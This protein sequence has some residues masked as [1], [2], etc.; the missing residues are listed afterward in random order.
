VLA[1]AFAELAELAELAVVPAVVLVVLFP[2]AVELAVLGALHHA[3]WPVLAGDFDSLVVPAAEGCQ[4]SAVAGLVHSVA[5]VDGAVWLRLQPW[6][7]LW[8][9]LCDSFRVGDHGGDGVHALGFQRQTS[10]FDER[11]LS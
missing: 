4:A 5:E 8:R 1:A 10:P 3:A 11:R 6:V 9:V 7:M 2:E